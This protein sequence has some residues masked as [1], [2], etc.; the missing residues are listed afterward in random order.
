MSLQSPPIFESDIATTAAHLSHHI[1]MTGDE[2]STDTILR[3]IPTIMDIAQR[4]IRKSNLKK[5]HKK[6]PSDELKNIIKNRDILNRAKHDFVIEVVN[7]IATRVN[8]D[9]SNIRPHISSI[10]C[11]ALACAARDTY[12]LHSKRRRWMCF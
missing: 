3:L 12:K 9:I 5:R 8:V 4:N 6:T 2:V 1:I 10:I 11:V 7:K